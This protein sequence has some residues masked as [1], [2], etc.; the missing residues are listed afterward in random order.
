MRPRLFYFSTA[1][2]VGGVVPAW[3]RLTPP[4][5]K[6]KMVKENDTAR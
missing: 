3:K 6:Q 4:E 2:S 1:N 5:D